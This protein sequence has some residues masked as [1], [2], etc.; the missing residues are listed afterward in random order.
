LG[1]LEDVRD[2]RNSPKG[3]STGYVPDERRFGVDYEP[4]P[5][6]LP[7]RTPDPQPRFG[8][9]YIGDTPLFKFLNPPNRN[10]SRDFGFNPF[11]RKRR[12][13]LFR[14]SNSPISSNS[15]LG[16]PIPPMFMRR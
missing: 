16:S 13:P 10:P 15:R 2:A 7:V 8:V 14:P 6:R 12:E 3:L 1:F 11:R 9:P 4:S 5:V